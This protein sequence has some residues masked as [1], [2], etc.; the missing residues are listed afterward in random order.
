[1]TKE[2]QSKTSVQKLCVGIVTF[3]LALAMMCTP[4]FTQKVNAQEQVKIEITYIY[5]NNASN[6][7]MYVDTQYV[8]TGTNWGEFLIAIISAI[9]MEP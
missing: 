2:K 4:M 1:M 7:S 8:P 9:R 5:V 6:N 3:A